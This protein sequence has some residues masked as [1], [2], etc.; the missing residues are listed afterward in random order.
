MIL[1]WPHGPPR[2]HASHPEP[3]SKVPHP[4]IF[5]RCRQVNILEACTQSIVSQLF[6]PC[7]RC[8]DF[9]SMSS[10]LFL[11]SYIIFFYVT[12]T[13]WKAEARLRV[14]LLEFEM[15]RISCVCMFVCRWH[16]GQHRQDVR[17]NIHCIEE[18]LPT[19]SFLPQDERK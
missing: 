7:A 1:G 10:Y 3:T 4:R 13:M 17:L 14:G 12:S 5:C 9:E 11:S 6:F 8:G 2:P 15:L 16:C 18:C 19:V